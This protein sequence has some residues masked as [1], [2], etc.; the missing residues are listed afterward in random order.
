[1][2]VHPVKFRCP[3]L[4]TSGLILI[5]GEDLLLLCQLH[6]FIGKITEPLAQNNFEI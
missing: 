4:N 2:V 5:G 3:G 1:M 6:A